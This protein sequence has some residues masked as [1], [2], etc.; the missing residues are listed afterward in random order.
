MN[1]IIK[2]LLLFLKGV[3]MG[4]ADVVPGVSGGTIAFITGIYETLLNSIKSVDLQALNYLKKFEIKALWEHVNGNFLIVLFAG[5]VT[6]FLSLSKVITYLLDA[7]PIQLW[8]FFFGLIVISALMVLREIKKW[9]VGVFIAIILG[10]LIAYFITSAVPSE[11]PDEPWFLFIAGAVAI[12]AMILPGISGS[13]IVLLF[14]KYEYMMAALNE[15]RI[16]DILVFA[17]GCLVGILSFARVISWLF[18][19]YHNI[20]VGVLS[21]FMIGALN[22]VWPWKETIETYVD[23]HGE[24]KPL[25]EVNVLPNEYLAKTGI[26]PHFIEAIGYAAAGFLIVLFIDRLSVWLK[27]D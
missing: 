23:R 4:S 19:K 24:V 25:Y 6:S 17:A 2:P 3:A 22:K 14:G 7:Y 15:R 1:H 21:G 18:K 5:I 20:T 27:K 11:T 8:S 12:C 26:E 16:V 10:G 9:N 13:F